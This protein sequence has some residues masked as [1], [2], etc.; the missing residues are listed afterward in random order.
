MSEPISRIKVECQ[1][2]KV[3]S[4]INTSAAK[5]LIAKH[6]GYIPC[7]ECGSRATKWDSKQFD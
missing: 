6:N 5:R 3:T 1:L 7:P 2:C 4:E